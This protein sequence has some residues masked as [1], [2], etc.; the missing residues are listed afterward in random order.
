VEKGYRV[1]EGIL[2]ELVVEVERERVVSWGSGS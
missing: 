1:L 2:L